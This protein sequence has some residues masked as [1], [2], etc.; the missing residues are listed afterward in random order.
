MIDHSEPYLDIF[1]GLTFILT[2][3]VRQGLS[4]NLRETQLL[5]DTLLYC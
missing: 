4:V 1:V 3:S 2:S 5:F